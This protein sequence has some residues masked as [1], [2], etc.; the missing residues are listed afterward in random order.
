MTSVSWKTLGST[1]VICAIG[2]FV[3]KRLP[4]LLYIVSS[5]NYLYW[6]GLFQGSTY[7]GGDVLNERGRNVWFARVKQ[8]IL[9]SADISL[10][11]VA[12]QFSL[13]M[14]ICWRPQGISRLYGKVLIHIFILYLAVRRWSII[15]SYQAEEVTA[16]QLKLVEETGI[17][18][19]MLVDIC[20]ERGR[21]YNEFQLMWKET[22]WASKGGSS[23]FLFWKKKT[24]EKL[25]PWGVIM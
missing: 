20:G 6:I 10:C 16:T 5:V 25:M 13:L 11:N 7:C 19:E 22:K 14:W 21:G 23:L 18:C 8:F 12:S 3:W 1:T 4:V 9:L 2:Y 15:R 24:R 17:G